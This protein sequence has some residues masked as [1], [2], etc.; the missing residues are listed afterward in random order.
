M[1]CKHENHKGL[2][3]K[4]FR[5]VTGQGKF[6]FYR[7]SHNPKN[8]RTLKQLGVLFTL[9]LKGSKLTKNKTIFIY[10]NLLKPFIVNGYRQKI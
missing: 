4:K 8:T 3:I 6:W 7:R 1:K 9:H 10:L 5:I 2:L